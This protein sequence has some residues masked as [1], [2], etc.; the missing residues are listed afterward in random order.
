MQQSIVGIEILISLHFVY[1][2]HKL[3]FEHASLLQDKILNKKALIKILKASEIA[4][5]AK[6]LVFGYIMTFF[7]D[8]T[9]ENVSRSRVIY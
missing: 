3:T 5:G 1:K 8:Y 9:S 4:P 7:R 2:Q 6:S